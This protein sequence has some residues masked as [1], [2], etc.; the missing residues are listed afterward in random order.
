[1]I[2]SNNN[3]SY[4]IVWEKL[5]TISEP[6]MLIVAII[7]LGRLLFEIGEKQVFGPLG[8]S[9]HEFEALFTL[10]HG[11]KATPTRLAVYS[12]M[13]P[14]KITRVLDKLEKHEAITRHPDKNDRRSYSL[15]ITEK[16]R[17]LLAQASEG[18]K[19]SC[20]KLERELG[21]ENIKLMSR[22]VIGM[23]ENIGGVTK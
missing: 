14:A 2:V 7:H 23:I 3:F 12:L 4:E 16:G 8:M 10:A 19:E 5:K 21:R 1:M 9:V 22:F 15:S 13:P 17:E 6:A 11:E 20:K 18:F